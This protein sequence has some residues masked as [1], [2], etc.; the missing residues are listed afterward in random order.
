MILI[1]LTFAGLRSTTTSNYFCH[2]TYETNLINLIQSP[3]HIKVDLV[4]TNN[5]DKISSLSITQPYALLSSDHYSIFFSINHKTKPIQKV[6]LHLLLS[7]L[8]Q[9][10]TAS[11]TICLVLILVFVFPQLTLNRYGLL[12]STLSSVRC[13]CIFS[14]SN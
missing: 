9:I 1:C 3:T 5:E 13:I 7:T 4:L 14:K 10:L 8:K 12:S 2:F 11:V 6:H